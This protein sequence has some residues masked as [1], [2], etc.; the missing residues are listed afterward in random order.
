M[1]IQLHGVKGARLLINIEHVRAFQEIT[2]DSK[3][4]VNKES[5]AKSL[6]QIDDKLVPVKDSILEIRNI[7]KKADLFGGEK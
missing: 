1:F 3:Y 5:G 6:V 4:A 7:M 2:D